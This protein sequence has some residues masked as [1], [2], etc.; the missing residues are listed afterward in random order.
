MSGSSKS[1]FRAR[2]ASYSIAVL[3]S[4][5]SMCCITCIEGP[6]PLCIEFP[7]QTSDVYT[8][9]VA[10]ADASCN[11]RLQMVGRGEF[12]GTKSY[13]LR[14]AVYIMGACR[15]PK[16]VA[17]PDSV[18]VWFEGRRMSARDA[19]R[20]PLEVSRGDLTKLKLEFDIDEPRTRS[21]DSTAS[22]NAHAGALLTI[23]LEGFLYY[24][25][26]SV[27][28]DTVRAIEPGAGH[29]WKRASESD[30]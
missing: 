24:D 12:D 21:I 14:L 11:V 10:V 26:S 30:L 3:S 22:Q 8:S 9:I 1:R 19:R 5:V 27:G 20:T 7:A 25:G 13:R 2:L 23:V 29:L 17:Y 15:S 4:T 28:L 6:R 18:G 16:L